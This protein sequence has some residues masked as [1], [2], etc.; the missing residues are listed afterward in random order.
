MNLLP[1]VIV[2]SLVSFL[3]I[4]VTINLAR[5]FGFVDDPKVSKHPALL[6]DKILPRAGGVAP[7]IGIVVATLVFLPLEKHLI[8][9]LLGAGVLLLVDTLD[10]KYNLHPLVRL[11]SGFLAASIV[12][13]SG[14]GI[15]SIALPF[16]GEIDLNVIDTPINFLGEHHFF[17]LADILAVLW[18]MTLTN[19]MNWSSGVD[20][21]L[22]SIVLV[23][24]VFIALL[25]SQFVSYD[26]SQWT[27]IKVCLIGI[28]AVLPLLIFN[29]HPAKILPG[30]GASTSLALIIATLAIFSGSKTAT[31]IL[32]LGVPIMDGLWTIGRRIYNRRSPI[33]GDREHLHHKLLNLG[34]S[35]QEITL[36]YGGV[37][38]VLGLIAVY[39]SKIT[40]F[41]AIL[42]TGAFLVTLTVFLGL[43][44]N[45]KKWKEQDPG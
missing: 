4:P 25:A 6:H 10:D 2:S 7:F 19:F 29:W 44:S 36:F 40:K 45:R 32:I 8:G 43:I 42:G 24:F 34:W 38:V 37:T 1:L 28:G 5:R 13:I 27:I 15:T 33:W 31:T 26:P 23:A 21:Q 11:G 18:I 41:W 39:A 17:P 35:H 3:L 30:D 14:V 12:V 16:F 9:M 20:G 22:P